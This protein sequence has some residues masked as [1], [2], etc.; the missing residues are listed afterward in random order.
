MFNLCCSLLVFPTGLPGGFVHSLIVFSSLFMMRS[1][2]FSSAGTLEVSILF[3]LNM[4]LKFFKGDSA[5]K[6]MLRFRR[7][8]MCYT[9][10]WSVR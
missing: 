2:N 9:T 3:P 5:T 10:S 8:V 4:F 6:E 1:E 7:L